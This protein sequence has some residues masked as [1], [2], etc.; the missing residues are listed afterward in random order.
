[1][2][3]VG[4]SVVWE[5][6]DLLRFVVAF[7]CCLGSSVAAHECS[8]ISADVERLECFDLAFPASEVSETGP[9]RGSQWTVQSET[10]AMTDETSVFL[11]VRSENPV[12]CSWNRGGYPVLFVRCLENTTSIIFSTDCHMTSS[13]YNNYGDVTYRLDNEE[14]RTR[15]FT[16]S[17]NNRSL[18]LWSGGEAIPFIRAM[19]DNERLL[20]RMTPFSDSP[21]EMEFNISGLDQA[22]VPL[23]E[24]CGW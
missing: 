16:E 13:R 7:F 14:P 22:I 1:M 11:S 23:R 15:G 21:I 24:A 17:T 12:T 4:G 6:D 9:E 10:S 18:G 8:D 5:L 20:A 19:L 3:G 2:K